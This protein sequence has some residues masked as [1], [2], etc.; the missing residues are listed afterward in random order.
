M[1]SRI[2]TGLLVGWILSLFGF[3]PVVQKG[4]LELFSIA[5]S[6]GTYY[7]IWA[8]LGLLFVPRAKVNN[9]NTNINRR[10]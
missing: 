2:L 3:I 8:V 6:I 9:S 7:F 10:Y 4:L 5:I 1:L